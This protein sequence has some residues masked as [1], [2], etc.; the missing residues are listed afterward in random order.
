MAP[1]NVAEWLV[2]LL[3]TET[4]V[5]GAGSNHFSRT[6]LALE[7]QTVVSGVA[8]ECVPS[9]DADSHR[10]RPEH[11]DDDRRDT[12]SGRIPRR[13]NCD[14]CSH[15]VLTKRRMRCTSRTGRTI[16]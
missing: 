4:A 15:N 14:G 10:I 9:C 11:R 8:R 16:I 12:I 13:E 6:V 7:N 1:I 2:G 3:N 5:G